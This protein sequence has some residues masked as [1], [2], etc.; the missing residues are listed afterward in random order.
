MHLKYF[1]PPKQIV[2]TGP[3]PAQPHPTGLN[4]P[5]TMT[6]TVQAGG[7]NGLMKGPVKGL[8][9]GPVKGPMKGPVKGPVKGPPSTITIPLTPY[10]PII[11]G[12]PNTG[13][14]F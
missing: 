1:K 13:F 9:K 3:A 2:F 4:G 11:P 7:V 8:M 14:L 12:L 10:V 6:V 5:T